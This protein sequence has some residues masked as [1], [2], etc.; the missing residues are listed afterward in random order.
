MRAVLQSTSHAD[1]RPASG[2]ASLSPVFADEGLNRTE[3]TSTVR[4]PAADLGARRVRI[5]VPAGSRQGAEAR[6][7]LE[8]RATTGKILLRP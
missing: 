4:V 8:G 5:Q 3:K 6:R 7:R 1:S 2:H